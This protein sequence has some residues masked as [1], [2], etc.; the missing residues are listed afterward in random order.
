M[1]IAVK[2]L[3]PYMSDPRLDNIILRC[4]MKNRKDAWVWADIFPPIWALTLRH[5]NNEVGVF[6]R[7]RKKLFIHGQVFLTRGTQD[8]SGRTTWSSISRDRRLHAGP[9]MDRPRTYGVRDFC[10]PFNLFSCT[11]VPY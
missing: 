2:V 10:N 6:E 8:M 5:N 7:R 1:E 3:G 4:S 9:L 11:H